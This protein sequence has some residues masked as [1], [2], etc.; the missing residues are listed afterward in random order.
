MNTVVQ[1]SSLL[2]YHPK[3]GTH[4]RQGLLYMQKK[5]GVAVKTGGHVCSV[6][7][8]HVVADT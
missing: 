6:P 4:K 3:Q 5:G 8:K 7:G 1:V 2:L